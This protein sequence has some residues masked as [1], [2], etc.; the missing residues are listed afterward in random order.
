MSIINISN[1]NKTVNG[2]LSNANA[3]NSQLPYVFQR[4]DA[5]AT[6]G[7]PRRGWL[8]LWRIVQYSILE[9]LYFG[10]PTNR[11]EI[12]PANMSLNP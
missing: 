10:V 12:L 5:A 11:A 4:E 8:S 7:M 2:I 6:S 9:I 1:P 3:A